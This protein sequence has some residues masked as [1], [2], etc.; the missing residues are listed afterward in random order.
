MYPYPIL[1]GMTL[2]DICL[3]IAVVS[4]LFMADRMGIMRSF[5]VRLQ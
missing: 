3:V 5:S 4:V 2:Y 1:L